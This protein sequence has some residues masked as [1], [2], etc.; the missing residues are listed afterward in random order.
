VKGQACTFRT[1]GVGKPRD[2]VLSPFFRTVHNRYSVYWD[3][4]T[5]EQLAQHEQEGKAEQ[6]RRQK[7]EAA[8][9]DFV[10]AGE[11]NSETAHVLKGDKMEVDEFINRP[12]RLSRGGWFSYDLKVPA[13]QPAALICTYWGGERPGTRVFDILV[14][15]QSIGSQTLATNKPGQFFDMTYPIPANLTTGK[16]KVTVSFKAQ[17]DKWAGAVFDVR[18]VK[19]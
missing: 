12:Y 10:T 4:V 13:G 18:T 14:N 7:I 9:V 16:D 3:L 5:P 8:T 17:D 19:Q 15:D 2:V 6:A 1:S 11:T